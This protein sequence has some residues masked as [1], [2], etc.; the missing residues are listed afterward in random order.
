M[1]EKLNIYEKMAAIQESGI[2]ILKNKKAQNHSYADLDGIMKVLQPLLTEHKLLLYNTTD[3]DST[4]LR[5]TL[6]TTVINV[7]NTEEKIESVFHIKEDVALQSQNQYMVAGSAITYFRRYAIACMFN[8]ITDS[9]GVANDKTSTKAQKGI[10]DSKEEKP[11][12]FVE[13]F[14]GMI[15]KQKTKDVMLKSFEAYKKVMN[16]QQIEEITKIIQSY[17]SK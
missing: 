8:L 17:D 6:K 5:T 7:E 9:D 10:E 15:A 13:I 4:C 1:A 12:D 11:V 2:P 16:A 14:K 3:F